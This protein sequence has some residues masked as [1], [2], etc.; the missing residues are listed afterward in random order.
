MPTFRSHTDEQLISLLREGS[1]EAFKEIYNRHWLAIYR[2]FF[3]KL[4]SKSLA[5]EYTQELFTSLWARR[6]EIII[7]GSLM[8]YFN[9]AVRKMVINYIR[10]K[11]GGAASDSTAKEQGTPLNQTNLNPAGG[12]TGD[13][14]VRT[15]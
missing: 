7:H 3:K 1:D 15:Q 12:N 14:A 11:Q 8:S 2:R 5:E 9:G 10:S 4:Q 6:H 13:S